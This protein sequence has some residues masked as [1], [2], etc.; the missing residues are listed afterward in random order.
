MKP[1]IVQGKLDKALSLEANGSHGDGTTNNFRVHSHSNGG[2]SE[3]GAL[4]NA[5]GPKGGASSDSPNNV[6]RF[7]PVLKDEMSVSSGN[8]S[9]S[10][11]KEPCRVFFV[12]TIQSDRGAKGKVDG[13]SGTVGSGKRVSPPISWIPNPQ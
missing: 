10:S 4:D 6:L 11:L 13:G 12:L 9:A 8:K 7:G 5:F 2:P 1:G 3:N